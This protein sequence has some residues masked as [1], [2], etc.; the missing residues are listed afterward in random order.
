MRPEM[1]VLHKA[2]GAAHIHAEEFADRM[3]AHRWYDIYNLGVTE[4]RNA[5]A[6]L[7]DCNLGELAA[8]HIK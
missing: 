6:V 7:I 5:Y 4:G 3:E 1:I 8:A 2:V